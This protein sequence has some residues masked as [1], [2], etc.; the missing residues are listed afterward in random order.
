MELHINGLVAVRLVSEGTVAQVACLNARQVAAGGGRTVEPEGLRF[1]DIVFVLPTDIRSREHEAPFS[2]ELVGKHVTLIV[3]LVVLLLGVL[4][5]RG[6]EVAEGDV[7]AALWPVL[8]AILVHLLSTNIDINKIQ[9]TSC[10]AI[11]TKKS[12]VSSGQNVPKRTEGVAA[13]GPK[14]Q[15]C[16][17][18]V[19]VQFPQLF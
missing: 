4:Q 19:E 12:S 10:I 9:Q 1:L 18:D 14:L 7:P 6:V 5:L 8:V 17:R 15:A 3:G 16:S 11:G 2:H 13:T